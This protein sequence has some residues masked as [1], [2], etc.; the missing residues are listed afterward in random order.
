MTAQHIKGLGSE[1]IPACCAPANHI[2]PECNAANT[3]YIR[4]AEAQNNNEG[5]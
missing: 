3:P 4:A 2:F 5:E 1:A